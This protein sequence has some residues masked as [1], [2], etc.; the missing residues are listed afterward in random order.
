MFLV[1]YEYEAYMVLLRGG[2]YGDL[3]F[4]IGTISLGL[5]VKIGVIT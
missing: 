2:N 1:L 5:A 3:H 4:E